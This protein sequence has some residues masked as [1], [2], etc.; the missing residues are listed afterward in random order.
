MDIILTVVIVIL[1]IVWASRVEN[2]LN[3]LNATMER[4]EKQLASK[5][6]K[7]EKK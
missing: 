4:I 1:V 6:A 7:K 5:D 2:G 3:K